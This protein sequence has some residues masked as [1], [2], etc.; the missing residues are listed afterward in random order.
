[1]G[2]AVAPPERRGPGYLA[3]FLKSEIEKWAMPIRESGV[4][5]D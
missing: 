3:P 5:V 2:V 1:M 4:S